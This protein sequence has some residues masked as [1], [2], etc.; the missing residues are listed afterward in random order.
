M[1]TGWDGGHIA[2]DGPLGVEELGWLVLLVARC[3]CRQAGAAQLGV[4]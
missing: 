4:L 3:M 1:R 2:L